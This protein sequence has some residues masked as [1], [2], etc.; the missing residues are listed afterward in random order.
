MGTDRLRS[1]GDHCFGG[2]I[3]DGS[4]L[5]SLLRNAVSLTARRNPLPG[6]RGNAPTGRLDNRAGPSGS[7]FGDASTDDPDAKLLYDPRRR[8]GAGLGGAAPLPGPSL[9]G[10]LFGGCCR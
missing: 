5:R 1:V 2:G 4:P 3:D 6:E 9:Y 8:E 7:G 10:P